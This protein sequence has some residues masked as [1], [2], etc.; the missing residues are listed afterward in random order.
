MDG[1]VEIFVPDLGIRNMK[2]TQDNFI[3]GS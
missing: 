2:N 1:A 3:P